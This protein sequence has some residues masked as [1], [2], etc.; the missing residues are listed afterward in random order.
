M[1]RNERQDRE[2]DQTK[3]TAGQPPRLFNEAA[4][5]CLKCPPT[6]RLR[7]AHL[8]LSYSMSFRVFLTQCQLL[9][10]GP[11]Q[12]DPWRS[13]WLCDD[14]ISAREHRKAKCQVERLGT[15]QL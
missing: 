12:N 7:R 15:L 5:G 14:L 1:R 11:Q 9:T 13:Q 10:H 4:Y 8:H 2:I 3:L 6:G